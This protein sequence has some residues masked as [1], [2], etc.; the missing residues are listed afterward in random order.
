MRQKRPLCNAPSRTQI[1]RN[2]RVR[3]LNPMD[4]FRS[5]ALPVGVA[6]GAFFAVTGIILDNYGIVGLGVVVAL[7]GYFSKSADS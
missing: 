1:G 2:V 6:M 5:A 7:A 4:R 3:R